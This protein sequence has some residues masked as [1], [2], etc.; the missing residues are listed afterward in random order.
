MIWE[1]ET[2][3]FLKQKAYS[4]NSIC[5][6]SIHRIPCCPYEYSLLIPD[7]MAA[8]GYVSI[9]NGSSAAIRITPRHRSAGDWVL[10]LVRFLRSSKRL[11]P[12]ARSRIYRAS[13]SRNLISIGSYELPAFNRSF[14]GGVL[15]GWILQR[16]GCG[17][18]ASKNR[19]SFA[20][21]IRGK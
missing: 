18:R 9:F 20:A 16:D 7:S 10:F 21:S 12:L 4:R 6:N 15:S 5:R 2:W 1:G 19:K 3:C 8:L 11:R 13:Q 14:W 17:G